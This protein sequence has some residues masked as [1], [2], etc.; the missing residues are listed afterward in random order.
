[1]RFLLLGGLILSLAAL[2]PALADWIEKAGYIDYAQHQV[3]V[4]PMEW[5]VDGMPDFDQKQDAW[6]NANNQWNWCG[7]VAAANC[8][9]WFDSKFETIKCK[10]LPAGT[11]IR[12]P[13]ISDHYS[14][15]YNCVVGAN[16]D[17]HD[18]PNVVP[19]ITLFG[20]SL[21]GGI[22]PAGVTAQ[23]IKTMIENWLA[24][25]AVNLAGHYT[26]RI[27]NA[28][29]WDYI[30]RQV[31]IS[32]DV[33]LLLG[34]WQRDPS[35]GQW[36]RFGGHWVTVAGVDTQDVDEISYSD[37]CVDNAELGMP[38]VVWNGWII[39]HV[40]IPGHG[41]GIHNDAGN[42]SHDHYPVQGS[43]SPGGGISPGNYGQEF[44]YSDWT[45][46][47]GLNRPARLDDFQSQYNPNW[48]VHTEIE[49]IVVVCPNFDY[50]DL[51]IDYPTI[52]I[53]SCGPA[54]PLTDKAWLGN[55]ISS[56]IQPRID[57][58]NQVYDQDIFDDG[59][60]FVGLPWIIGTNVQVIVQVTTGPS[61]AGEPLY[62]SAWKDGNVDGDFDDGPNSPD[63]DPDEDNWLQCTEWVIQ[64]ALVAGAGVYTFTF[65][66][67]GFANIEM[68]DLRIRVRLSSQP[69]GRYGYGGYW[70]G[71]VSN[72]RGTYDI[73]WVLGEVEDYIIDDGQQLAV[74]LQ[75]FDAVPGNRWVNL[76]W[77]TA[78]ETDNAYFTLAR[79]TGTNA[80]NEITRVNSRGNSAS[81]QHYSYIDADL[82]NDVT[83][84]YRLAAVDIFGHTEVLALES[85]TPRAEAVPLEYSLAQNHPNP[86]NAK[87]EI[88]YSLRESGRVTLTIYNATGQLVKTLVDGYQSA[89]RYRVSFNADELASG[90]YLYKLEVNDFTSV[91]KMVL[92]K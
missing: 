84:E 10:S 81:A 62:L 32:Q 76:L 9:W 25:A 88:E 91:K 3:G 34:F 67:P 80:W 72:G 59:V 45:N 12:P 44:D 55:N 26:V 28:P 15:V 82:L 68:W 1:M 56:E 36:G 90:I 48:P 74:E 18:P 50:G 86:F 63:F 43:G 75:R 33:I 77:T 71:G 6:R 89:D 51:Q 46:F 5:P 2:S 31:Q 65:C 24:S 54:H 20:N 53:E 70:G 58:A 8:L 79:R 19:W 14:L 69:V 29:T 21:P 16:L 4:P 22:P 66:D 61:Y 42:V 38:G 35:S 64:D 41:P 83:Y 78:S 39:P 73:D 52:D 87:T 30:Y 40:P 49:D 85:A 23:Q 47:Q 92:L 60:Q 17:D 37:P 11:L 57:T 13:T 27:V 7:P